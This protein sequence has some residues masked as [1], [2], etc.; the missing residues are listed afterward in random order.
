MSTTDDAGWVRVGDMLQVQRV[1]LSPR[2][3]N[4]AL[5]CRERE[6]DYRL[7]W[8]VENHA[9]TNYRR[10]TR[11]S[12]EIAYGW[13]PGSIE[14][15]LNGGAPVV[16]GEGATGAEPSLVGEDVYERH[17][18]DSGL[19][20]A[21]KAAKVRE[22][23]DHIAREARELADLG[24]EPPQFIRQDI[25]RLANGEDGRDGARRNRPA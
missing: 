20:H 25:R 11:T 17:I 22:H 16:A 3:K 7:A 21:D 13:Q 15:V 19:P 12:I 5:F 24:I 18:L 2:Y 1:E 23:R 14:R 9:R 6:I 10:G 4:L 8:D